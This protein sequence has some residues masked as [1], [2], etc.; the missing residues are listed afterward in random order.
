MPPIKKPNKK[1]NNNPQP[2]AN[3]GRPQ[4]PVCYPD[5]IVAECRGD[6]ALTAQQC[7]DLLG[8]EEEPDGVKF[9]ADYD[10]IDR[11]GKKVRLHNNV[12]NRQLYKSTFETLVQQHLRRRW[13]FN[14]EPI[15]IG[16]T[17]VVLNG[18]HCLVS[19]PL[20]AQDWAGKHRG[21]W[22]MF[23]DSEPTMEKVVEYGID[24]DDGTVN[25]MDTCKPRSLTDVIYRSEFFA[26]VGPAQRKIAAKITDYAVR[27][28]WSRTGVP[29]MPFAPRRTHAESLD[30]VARHRR[31][32]EAVAAVQKIDKDKHL[33]KWISP[34]YAAGFL[35]LAA[36][37]L[38]D[39][40][41]YRAA[42]NPNEGILDLSLF[43]TAVK[44]LT[45]LAGRSLVLQEVRNAIAALTGV[46]GETRGPASER[47][48]VLCKAWA[49]YAQPHPREITEE[50]LVIDYNEDADGF[51]EL[52]DCP[53]VGGVDV[54][55]EEILNRRQEGVYKP[56]PSVKR[57]RSVRIHANGDDP[58]P[59]EIY[60]QLGP[61]VRRDSEEAEERNKSGMAGKK[62]KDK[63]NG[64]KT[65][66]PEQADDE[67]KSLSD[68]LADL[69]RSHPGKLLLF[70]TGGSYRAWGED[71]RVV[72][73]V[74]KS[75]CDSGSQ[76]GLLIANFKAGKLTES[77]IK[78]VG[79]GYEAVVLEQM[80]GKTVVVA[81]GDEEVP[82]TPKK[83]K[84]KPDTNK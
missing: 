61:A 15:I 84:K 44:F 14:G 45:D 54:G 13:K 67:S 23:W 1:E 82:T 52:A 22:E 26:N 72:K 29:T 51:R 58:T 19:V 3:I 64:V 18:Q 55:D 9:G 35:Y 56:R 39:G 36:A 24:E 46:D 70:K 7:K 42:D 30:F 74:L 2:L 57:E 68:E 37:G 40:G 20:A 80:D 66:G 34:G 49:I 69:H 17:G 47:V 11:H 41:A 65:T 27:F 4:R 50:D 73:D 28:L 77:L 10:L 59:E 53:V 75:L 33:R 16:K 71:A 5:F 6:Q 43:D 21:Y 12:K 79:A 48:A 63:K 78:L 25:T 38:S 60:D 62:K 32:L 81:A 31:I 83:L 8:W 76:S